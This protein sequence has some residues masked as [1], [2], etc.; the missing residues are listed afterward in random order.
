MQKPIPELTPK[1]DSL[2]LP[3]MYN[4]A[5]LPL[6]HYSA[7]CSKTAIVPTLARTVFS[8]HLHEPYKYAPVRE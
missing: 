4:Y 7:L 1:H 5:K 8:A 6:P 3:K 2:T